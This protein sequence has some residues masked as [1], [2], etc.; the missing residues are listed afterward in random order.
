MLGQVGAAPDPL[1][2]FSLLLGRKPSLGADRARPLG[3]SG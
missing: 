3:K 2:D 1:G